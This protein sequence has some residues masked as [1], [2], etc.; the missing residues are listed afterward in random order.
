MGFELVSLYMKG[1]LLDNVFS[2]SKKWLIL[3]GVVLPGSAKPHISEQQDTENK[4]H[5]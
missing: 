5:G 1:V 3:G 4:R 2:I